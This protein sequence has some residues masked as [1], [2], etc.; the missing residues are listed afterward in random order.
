MTFK[1]II[2]CPVGGLENMFKF[3]CEESEMLKSFDGT[4]LL[5]LIISRAKTKTEV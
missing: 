5:D 3:T 2:Q 1:V 4:R